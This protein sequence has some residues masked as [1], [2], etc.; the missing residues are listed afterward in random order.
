VSA[1]NS[2]DLPAF[3]SPTMPI[4]MCSRPKDR[5]RLGEREPSLARTQSAVD[6]GGIDEDEDAARRR[7]AAAERGRA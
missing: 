6:A 5:S 4:F 3:G 7:F 2:E 1:L